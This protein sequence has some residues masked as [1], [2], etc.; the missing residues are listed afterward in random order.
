MKNSRYYSE[1]QRKINANPNFPL[2][3]EDKKGLQNHKEAKE[4]TAILMEEMQSYLPARWNK[5][6]SLQEIKAISYRNIVANLILEYLTVKQRASINDLQKNTW[7]KMTSIYDDATIEDYMDTL[8]FL[9]NSGFI[10]EL[11]SGDK[12][13]FS[14]GSAGIKAVY[15]QTFANAASNGLVNYLTSKTSLIGLIIS[16]VSLITSLTIL[17]LTICSY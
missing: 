12:T 5:K 11:K 16:V 7:G 15:N 9:C 14:I 1:L 2:G 4:R 17:I 3:D 13:D 8:S 6:S 10:V